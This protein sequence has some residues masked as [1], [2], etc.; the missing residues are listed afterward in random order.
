ML[1]RSVVD[2]G[3]ER[4]WLRHFTPVG[5]VE[6]WIGLDWNPREEV[7]QLACYDEVR[8]ANFDDPLPLA[9]GIADVVVSLHVFEHLPRPGAT[10]AELSR[11]LKP[12]GIFLGCTPTMPGWLARLREGYLRASLRRGKVVP[13]GHITVLSPGRWH[14]L[15]RDAGL[16]PEFVTGSHAV[17]RTGGWLENFPAWVRLNQLWGALFP[18]LGSECCLQARRQDPWDYKA[19]KL[20]SRGRHLRPVWI[21]LTAA[22]ALALGWAWLAARDA[23]QNHQRAAIMSWLESHQKGGDVFILADCVSHL[24]DATREDVFEARDREELESI[25]R[26]HPHSHILVSEHTARR[27]V[28]QYPPLTWRVDSWFEI[29][30]EDFLMLRTWPEGTPLDEYLL[31]MASGANR[32]E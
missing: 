23:H 22:A 1:F 10:L 5:A 30:E 29:G 14:S 16:E 9:S 17:R 19:A 24:G 4:G 13:G 7:R 20:E 15:A 21:S 12:G 32:A 28:S 18:A 6:R 26:K 31:G 2:A 3:C 8:H 25:L 27:F 11:V